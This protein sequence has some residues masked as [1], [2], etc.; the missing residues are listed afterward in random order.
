M[1]IYGLLS[2]I[3]FLLILLFVEINRIKIIKK[4]NKHLD[5]KLKLEHFKYKKEIHNI[6]KNLEENFKEYLKEYFLWRFFDDSF[7][8]KSSKLQGA[9]SNKN[10]GFHVRK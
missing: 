1:I 5:I 2:V 3:F 10:I 9:N 8:I 7:L 6:E 4:I